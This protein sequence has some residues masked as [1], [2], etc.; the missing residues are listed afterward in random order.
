MRS[1]A[2]IT[3]LIS[4]ALLPAC[5]DS[6]VAKFLLF[7]NTATSIDSIYLLPDE[8]ASPAYISL[9]PMEMK[10]HSISLKKEKSDG[11]YQLFYTINNQRRVHFF[12]YFS[13]GASLEDRIVIEILP[14]TVQFQPKYRN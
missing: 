10:W 12:G 7:N 3:L 8:S 9:Q 1:A 11:S 2:I 6:S 4:L 5:K 14:D 13:N